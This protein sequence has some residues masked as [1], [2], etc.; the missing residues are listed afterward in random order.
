MK[1]KPLRF[2]T[3]EDLPE[4]LK[5]IQD[6]PESLGLGEDFLCDKDRTLLQLSLWAND[7]VLF[8]MEKD[9]E[10]IGLVAIGASD[11]WWSDTVFFTTRLIYLRK[12]HRNVK[13]L[14]RILQF[15]TNYAKIKGVPMLLD[16]G[17][18]SLEKL[19]KKSKAMTRKGFEP[20][21]ISMYRPKE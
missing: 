18:S 6:L 3:Q 15:L 10:I 9:N 8:K 7:R 17:D 14:N 11:V 20:V 4:C 1:K 16:V 19:I 21:G 2:V 13:N 5:L 12:D